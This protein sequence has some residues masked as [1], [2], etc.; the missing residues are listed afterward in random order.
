MASLSMEMAQTRRASAGWVKPSP[1][2]G[3]TETSA[4]TLLEES[5][6]LAWRCCNIRRAGR[7]THLQKR[8]DLSC[9][10]QHRRQRADGTPPDI[11]AVWAM[12]RLPIS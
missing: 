5:E 1:D 4:L 2:S 6:P 8:P 7:D 11:Y 10:Q 12:P 3:R 9:I